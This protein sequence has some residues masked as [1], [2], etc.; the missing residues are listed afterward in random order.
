MMRRALR[1]AERGAGQV[2]PN[3]KVGAIVVQ[4]GAIVGEGWHARFGDP[5][6]EV[7]ALRAAGE[8]ARGATVYVTLEPCNHHGKTPPCTAA[9]IA[10][11]VARVVYAVADPN[12]EATGGARRLAEAGIVVEGGVL[13]DEASDAN[14]LFLGALSVHSRPFITLKLAVSLDGSIVGVSRARAELTG[15]ESRRVVHALRAESDGVAVGIGTA[16]ADDPALTVR[17]APAP[18]RAPTRVVFDRT[19]RLPLDGALVRSARETPVL[20]L[21]DGSRQD[22]E[23]ALRARGVTVLPVASATQG[24]AALRDAGLRTLFVEGG[25]GLASALMEARMVDRLI[26]F[27]A[28]VLLGA[29]AL[30]AFAALSTADAASVRLELRQRRN[31]GRDTMSVYRVS[32]GDLEQ[33]GS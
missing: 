15:A 16:L 2:A 29:G 33:P 14:A 3:P 12:P 24:L 31:V 30:P 17:H 21:T 13:Q 6:A 19:A 8:R 1:L 4:G 23:A 27:Q 5:H 25:A 18:R 11:G 28:P 10:A 9:L 22:A 20:V 26:I 32:F 7:M